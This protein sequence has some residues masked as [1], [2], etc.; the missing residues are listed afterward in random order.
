MN[1]TRFLAPLEG[2][3]DALAGAHLATALEE[4][5][6]PRTLDVVVTAILIYPGLI[7]QIRRVGLGTYDRA[8]EGDQDLDPDKQLGA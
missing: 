6:L 2:P 8:Q 7:E 4:L 3:A 5:P 1:A